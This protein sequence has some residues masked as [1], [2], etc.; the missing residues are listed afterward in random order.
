MDSLKPIDV[1]S[2]IAEDVARQAV[3]SK[4]RHIVSMAVFILAILLMAASLIA[5]VY[6]LVG[7]YENDPQISTMVPAIILCLGIG[8]MGFV[9]SAVVAIAARHY[10]RNNRSRLSP[11]L[12][13]AFLVPGWV[14]SIVLG[15]RGV[16]PVWGNLAVIVLITALIIWVWGPY[17]SSERV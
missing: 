11:F 4:R 6:V 12:I 14:F 5:P 10:L 15:L 2:V 9:P 17:R 16:G 1:Y 13:T 8:A 3:K 7:F